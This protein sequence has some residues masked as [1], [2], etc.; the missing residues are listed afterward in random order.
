VPQ[1][2]TRVAYFDAKSMTL[3]KTKIAPNDYL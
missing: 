2:A 1:M 3:A